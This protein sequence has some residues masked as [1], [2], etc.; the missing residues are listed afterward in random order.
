MKNA[1]TKY[2]PRPGTLEEPNRLYG[3]AARF[4]EESEILY[5][6]NVCKVPFIEVIK[7]GAFSRTLRENDDIRALFSHDKSAVLGR[8]KAGTLKLSEDEQ[9]LYFDN[10]LPDTTVARDLRVSLER[11]DLDGCSFFGYVMEDEIELRPNMPALRTITEISLIEVTPATA[12]PAYTTTSVA[13]R[14]AHPEL[15]EP[16]ARGYP[17]TLARARLLLTD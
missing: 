9:G 7:P 8:T 6:K 15:F 4:N 13:I 12:F 1:E 17:L 10:L 2:S 5:D 16:P 3:Y 11:G 14:S